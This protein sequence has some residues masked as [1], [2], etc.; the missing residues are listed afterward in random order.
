MYAVLQLVIHGCEAEGEDV[1]MAGQ[2]YSLGIGHVVIVVVVELRAYQ[3]AVHEEVGNAQ[4]QHGAVV[5]HQLVKVDGIVAVERS[6]EDVAV[7]QGD[8]SA[9]RAHGLI[10]AVEAGE[11]GEYLLVEVIGADNVVGG[12]PNVLVQVEGDALD[13][14][15]GQAVLGAKRFEEPY[16][17]GVLLGGAGHTAAVGAYPHLAVLVERQVDN[18]GTHEYLVRLFL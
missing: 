17:L 18:V 3:F 1:A 14:L 5:G 2:Y 8:G 6:E 4:L 7:G 9:F 12:K 13:F 15:G 10:H 16:A 11:G